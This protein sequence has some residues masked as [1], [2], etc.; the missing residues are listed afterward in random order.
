LGYTIR[1]CK[2]KKITEKA[3]HLFNNSRKIID[4]LE[5]LRTKAYIIDGIYHHY[6][7]FGE[8]GDIVKIQR[9][10]NSIVKAYKKHS[11]EEWHWFEDK[12]TYDNAKIPES[13]FL[14]Y[15]ATED[16]KYLEVAEQSIDFL[17]DILFEN[18]E[19]M[20][21]GQ[22]GWHN[23]DGKKAMFDQQPIDASS[24][25]LAYLTAYR[26]TKNRRYYEKAVLSFNWFLGRN[27]LKQMLYDE[28]TGGCFDGL[29]KYSLNLNQGAESTIS[30]LLA[31][32]I[33]EEIKRE[34]Q[35]N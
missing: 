12:L 10:S 22:N 34:S 31:R 35:E 21:I 17:S 24:M 30:Y 11:T 26:I 14:A 9:L 13:L 3:E 1:K 16:E 27:H 2:N 8:T 6:K 5:S 25:V 18:D 7:K 20:P 32:L 33:L 19:L 4:N 23:K 15:E 29:G 28:G